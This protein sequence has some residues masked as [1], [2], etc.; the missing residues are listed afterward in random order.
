VKAYLSLLRTELLLA[1]RRGENLLITLVIPPVLMLV[2]GGLVPLPTA[3][4]ETDRLAFLVPGILA[5]AVLSTSLVSLGIA[6]A[7]ERYYGVLKRLVGSPA[8]L[9]TILLAKASA[10]LCIEAM[11]VA[12]V[13]AIAVV[14]FGWAPTGNPLLAGLALLVGSLAF[15]GLGLLLAGTLRAEGTLAAANALYLAFL[16]LGGFIF[17]LGL[18]PPLV[19]NV[20]AA[21]PAALLAEATRGALHGGAALERFGPAF[22][23]LLLWALLAGAAAW[24]SFRAD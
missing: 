6:T 7:Y 8:P 16:L 19:S 3:D 9:A 17:P 12:L 11:Q 24:R 14:V 21:L 15:A 20:A 10:V 18:L 2:F 23:G 1:S 4:A 5:L 22:G 13:G